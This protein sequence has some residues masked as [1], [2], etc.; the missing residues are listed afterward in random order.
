MLLNDAGKCKNNKIW[1]SVYA[2]YFIKIVSYIKDELC[3]KLQ[4]DEKYFIHLYKIK[5][6]KKSFLSISVILSIICNPSY[7]R[8]MEVVMKTVMFGR[9]DVWKTVGRR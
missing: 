8:W 2:N 3:H 1:A 9:R 6:L 5:T 7:R 4:K